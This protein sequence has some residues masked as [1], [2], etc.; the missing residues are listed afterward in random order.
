M[1]EFS[2]P[3]TAW[4]PERAAPRAKRSGRWALSLALLVLLIGATLLVLFLHLAADLRRFLEDQPLRYAPELSRVEGVRKW[5]RR[6]P[7]SW[8]RANWFVVPM[9]QSSEP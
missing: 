3:D 4:R 7:R 8:R 5:F 9:P 2:P 6:H 1:S